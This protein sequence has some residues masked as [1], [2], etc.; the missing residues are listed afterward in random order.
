MDGMSEGIEHTLVGHLGHRWVSVN[1]VC[2]VLE[3]GAHLEGKRPF[4]DQFADVRADALNAEDAV[5]VFTSHHTDEA[6]GFLCLLGK[7]AAVGGQRELARDDGVTG[8]L[9]LVG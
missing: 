7:R 5:V 9:G 3:D 4:A 2:D 8:F 6:A 1:R